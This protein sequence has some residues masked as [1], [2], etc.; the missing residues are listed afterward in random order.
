MSGTLVSAQW[1]QEH[2]SEVIMCDV[3][4]GPNARSTYIEE[5]VEGALWVDLETQLSAPYEDASALGRHPLPTPQTFA[6]TLGTLGISPDSTV[7]LYDR[8]C[9]IMAAARMWWMLRAM[10]HQKVAVVDGGLQALKNIGLPIATGDVVPVPT[11]YPTTLMQYQW[12]LVDMED[13]APAIAAGKCLV[14]VRAAAR[15]EGVEEPIDPVAGH[16]P[17]AIN[18]PLMEVISG[19]QFLSSEALQSHFRP[20]QHKEVIV[21]C[22]SGVTACHTILAL[23]HAG[24]PVPALYNGSW[25]QWCRNH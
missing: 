1:V 5:H 19:G 16:I 10:G 9:G 25:S 20:L 6:H 2:F 13:I 22:G 7:V 8:T 14:D 18:M 21:H 4:A 15:Y 3:V 23:V 12:P 11:T 17:G 24:Y